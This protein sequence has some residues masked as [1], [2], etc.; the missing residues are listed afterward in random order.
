MLGGALLEHSLEEDALVGNVLVDDPQAV[1][2]DGED[3]RVA[4]LS[5]RLERCKRRER[6]FFFSDVERGRAA[7][8]GNGIRLL[9]WRE[10]RSE[11]GVFEAPS[12]R[13]GGVGFDCDATFE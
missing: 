12:H 10:V 1:F 9:W 13:N 6:R 5:Q 11:A 8:I 4:D 7:V 3:E 2:V